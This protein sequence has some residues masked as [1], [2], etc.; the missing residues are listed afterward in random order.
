MADRD[1]KGRTDTGR[2]KLSLQ[3][4]REIRERYA[5][6]GISQEQLGKEY[7][8]VQTAISLIVRRGVYRAGLCLAY[9]KPDNKTCGER[10]GVA[11]VT[12]D[13]VREIR[14]RHAT[15]ASPKELAGV[16]GISRTSI[17]K[18]VSRRAW[19]HVD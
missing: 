13:Q 19:R 4:V 6:G 5:Q 7:G 2:R 16:F 18:I 10:T 15:G 8:V 1:R 17:Q 3:Q 12:A 14:R 11:K 9:D